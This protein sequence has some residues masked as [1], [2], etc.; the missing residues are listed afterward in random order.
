MPSHA[1]STPN[2]LLHVPKLIPKSCRCGE[3]FCY[4]CG[5]PWKLC[6]GCGDYDRPRLHERATR[7]LEIRAIRRVEQDLPLDTRPLTQRFAEIDQILRVDCDHNSFYYEPHTTA[8]PGYCMICDWPH[9]VKYIFH[10]ERCNFTACKWCHN[11]Y[12]WMGGVYLDALNQLRSSIT[13]N[14]SRVLRRTAPAGVSRIRDS[15]RARHP[16]TNLFAPGELAP[17]L[18]RSAGFLN[19]SAKED[20][21]QAKRTRLGNVWTALHTGSSDVNDA[22]E[23]QNQLSEMRATALKAAE[24]EA[25]TSQGENECSEE[26]S[27]LEKRKRV[28]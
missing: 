22:G 5:T 21:H 2:P 9:G 18:P 15:R 20:E 13:R 8:D 17:R 19:M 24:D 10:C 23:M 26:G 3:E 14:V 12:S 7:A 28:E 11:H 4:R 27:G 25:K 16:K 1:V 6:G